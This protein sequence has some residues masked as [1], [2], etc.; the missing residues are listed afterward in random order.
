MSVT[1]LAH[2]LFFAVRPPSPLNVQMS[3]FAGV[4]ADG[5]P[6]I[7]YDHLHTTLAI[8]GDYAAEPKHAIETLLEAG[9]NVE[10][11]PFVMKVDKLAA[12][13]RSVALRPSRRIDELYVLQKQIIQ[14][15]R[16]LGLVLRE[17]WSF[18]PHI[19]LF[20]RDGAPFNRSLP[21][22]HWRVDELVLVHSLVGLTEHHV[23]GRWP[24]RGRDD[25]QLSLF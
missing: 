7:R 18:N 3:N 8:T 10:A 1:P 11:A 20:Y 16:R 9:D 6:R 4:E 13:R 22:F 15:V 2:R 5:G 21:G 19:T 25:P 12:S 14:A 23:L 17:G 24:L